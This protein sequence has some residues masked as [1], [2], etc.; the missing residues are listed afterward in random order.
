MSAQPR[1]IAIALALAIVLLSSTLAGARIPSCQSNDAAV[2]HDFLELAPIAFKGEEGRPR[3]LRWSAPDIAV[4][5][6]A[7]PAVPSDEKTEFR[8]YHL[9][10]Q[11]I[12]YTRTPDKPH[13]HV[14]GDGDRPKVEVVFMP[15]AAIE[16]EYLRRVPESMAAWETGPCRALIHEGPRDGLAGR[17]INEIIGATILAA[18]DIERPEMAT[19][20]ANAFVRGLGLVSWYDATPF[21]PRPSRDAAASLSL[22]LSLLYGLD[23]KLEGGLTELRTAVTGA[24]AA[25]RRRSCQ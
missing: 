17:I 4:R 16:A 20:L 14:A 1:A 2:V 13:L 5:T 21:E 10:Q 23:G 7:W 3:L 18:S 11:A 24:A 6:I 22:A 12:V 15:A 9:V 19:C 25:A 8:L